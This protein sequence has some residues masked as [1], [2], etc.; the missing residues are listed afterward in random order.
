MP[1]HFQIAFEFFMVALWLQN[2]HIIF[3]VL[4]LKKLLFKIKYS[5]IINT[6]KYFLINQ[7][8]ILY[9]KWK[10]RVKKLA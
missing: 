10:R 3:Y 9:I 1:F 5:K 7:Y 4:F 8:Y 2:V 6:I